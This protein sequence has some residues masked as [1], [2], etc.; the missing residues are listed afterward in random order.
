MSTAT[1]DRTGE[2][3]Q[4]THAEYHADSRNSVSH[5]EA[6][7]YRENPELYWK[8]LIKGTIPRK[9]SSALDLGNVFHNLVLGPD[10]LIES[11]NFNNA[12]F[13]FFTQCPRPQGDEPDFVSDSGSRYWIGDDS[14]IRQSDHWGSV[15][16]CYWGAPN[17]SDC[18]TVRYDR[19]LFL[20]DAFI[21]IPED[22]LSKSGSKAGKAWE[23]W[24][25]DQPVGS[26]LLKAE[27]FE[28]MADWLESLWDHDAAYTL[29]RTGKGF[30]ERAIRW[31]DPQTG[32]I[33]RCKP[34]R[35]TDT[36]IADLKTSRGANPKSFAKDAQNFGYHRQAAWYQD[37]VEA[38]TGERLPFVFAVIEKNP[39]YR[40]ETFE[41]EDEWVETGR[42]QNRHII[43][44]IAEQRKRGEW[45]SW[46]HGK[47]IKL[48]APRWSRYDDE[49]GS[50]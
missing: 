12:T 46:T 5:S 23:E 7:T 40:V 48:S 42:L 45:R 43:E 29:L 2:I 38:L 14:V 4:C 32:L 19:L 33:L 41:M 22:V 11:D 15:G 21:P 31:T 26:I 47:I 17:N 1:A 49:Y 37:G 44:R 24:R 20:D 16:S 34:D 36:F 18:G 6:E 8:M 28:P 13:G 9:R 10:H 39:P 25:D 27:D 3:W 50:C 30:F 35:M